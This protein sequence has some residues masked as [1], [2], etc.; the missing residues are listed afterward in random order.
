MAASAA[1]AHVPVCSRR[2]KPRFQLPVNSPDNLQMP[3]RHFRITTCAVILRNCTVTAEILNRAA[4]LVLVL[5]GLSF[6][7][8]DQLFARGRF[9]SPAFVTP[10]TTSPLVCLS[11]RLNVRQFT[12]NVAPVECEIAPEVAVI[13][14]CPAPAG[15]LTPCGALDILFPLPQ[16]TS[17]ISSRMPRQTAAI[18]AIVRARHRVLFF[19][20]GTHAVLK[21][22]AAMLPNR[23]HSGV[24]RGHR[25]EP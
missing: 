5:N 12:T 18:L 15:V 8:S 11:H 25:R 13:V 16:A 7:N 22:I 2:S 17:A 19:V 14:I 20:A 9:H 3:I 23:N 24:G 21:T 1:A 6:S 10:E 4:S